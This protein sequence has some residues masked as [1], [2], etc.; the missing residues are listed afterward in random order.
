MKMN[1]NA[2][3]GIK[4]KNILDLLLLVFETQSRTVLRLLALVPEIWPC[5]NSILM[6]KLTHHGNLP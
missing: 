3:E 2:S 1:L 6:K 5:K 4:F